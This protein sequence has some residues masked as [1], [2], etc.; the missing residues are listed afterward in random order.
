MVDPL[1]VVVGDSG[2]LEVVVVLDV[3]PGDGDGGGNLVPDPPWEI[4]D[5]LWGVVGHSGHLQLV[6]VLEAVPLVGRVPL[7]Y[8]D[9]WF[10][11]VH[12]Q[13][14]WL[15]HIPAGWGPCWPPSQPTQQVPHSG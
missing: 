10:W 5:P 12:Y 2:H 11:N 4:G 6:V 15:T 3:V 13:M 8:S 14:Y 7:G 1:W 9:E